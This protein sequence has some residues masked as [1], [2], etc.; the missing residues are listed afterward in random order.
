MTEPSEAINASKTLSLPLLR[1]QLTWERAK[2]SPKWLC[3][4]S[5][6]VPVDK[7]DI[8]NLDERGFAIAAFG[9]TATTPGRTDWEPRYSDGTL[10]TPFRDGSHAAWDSCRLKIP[11]FVVYGDQWQAVEA[12]RPVDDVELVADDAAK[13]GA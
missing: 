1:L 12:K 8:R 13:G 3:H 2:D 6:L 5:L 10:E 11:A 4:Y 9:H 7:Y